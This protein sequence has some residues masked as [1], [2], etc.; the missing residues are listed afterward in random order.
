MAPSFTIRDFAPGDAPAVLAINNAAVPAMNVL[1][2]PALEWLVGHAA[3]ARVAEDDRGVAGVLLCLGEGAGYDSDNYR[4][5]SA[6]FR[7]F[8]YV[9]RIAVAERARSRGAGAALYDDLAQRARG[10]WHW[11]LAEVNA[12]PPNPRS[13]AFH[14]RHGFVRVGRVRHTYPGAHA[15]LVTMLARPVD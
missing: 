6:R 14:E 7:G 12:E 5:F 10:R 11:I 3:H 13:L 1:D 2:G 15:S 4:W 9:D 8:V